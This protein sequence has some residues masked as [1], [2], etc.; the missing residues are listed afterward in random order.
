MTHYPRLIEDDVYF[1]GFSSEKSYG[2]RSYLIRHPAGN[3]MTDAPRFV[4]ELADRIAELGGLRWIF[5]THRDDVAD[6]DLYA[7]RFGA[8][9]IIHEA[10]LDAEPAAEVVLRGLEPSSPVPGFTIIPVPGH[11]RGHCVLLYKDKFLF[12]GDHL[13]GDEKTGRLDA[14]RDYCW[15]DWSEQTRSMERLRACRFEWVL[16][17]HGCRLHLPAAR[18]SEELAALTARMGKPEAVVDAPRRN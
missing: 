17:G 6:A 7:E 14:F 3:W 12:S 8:K 13:E 1:C 16:P 15:Y 4:P 18:M 5:L 10:D 11:T 9:R 2:A